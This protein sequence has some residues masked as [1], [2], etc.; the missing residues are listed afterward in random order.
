MNE[1]IPFRFNTTQ[2]RVVKDEKGEP[3]FVGKDVCDA[4]GYADAHQAITKHCKY[5]KLLKTVD[6]TVL[7]VPSRGL[8][9]FPESDLYRLTI[10]SDKPEADKFEDWIVEEVL[11]SIRKTGTYTAPQAKSTKLHP[12]AREAKAALS[13]AKTFGLTGNQALLS[14]NTLIR[15]TYGVDLMAQIEQTHLTCEVQE[16]NYCP[17]LWLTCSCQTVSSR[18]L[19]VAELA[20]STKLAWPFS[21][22]TQVERSF[23]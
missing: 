7:D 18:N 22:Q 10:K 17:Y 12:L 4:L 9:I 14:A 19:G 2:I 6:S 5:A 21:T 3:W 1:I 20:V 13:I 8:L 16:K 15:K 23:P 11:P